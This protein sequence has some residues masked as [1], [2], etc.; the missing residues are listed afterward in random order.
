M[1]GLTK[2]IIK[3]SSDFYRPC[4]FNINPET[5]SSSA[6]SLAALVSYFRRYGNYYAKLQSTGDIQ[7]VPNQ[8]TL[9][10]ISSLLGQLIWE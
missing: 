6:C 2:K 8:L 4:I 9:E 3:Y 7:Q 10:I 1:I 5:E